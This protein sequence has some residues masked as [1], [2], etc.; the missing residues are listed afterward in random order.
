MK[1]IVLAAL[2]FSFPQAG[3]VE[4]GKAKIEPDGKVI[5]TFKHKFSSDQPIPTC[6]ITKGKAQIRATGRDGLHIIGRAGDK[7]EWRCQ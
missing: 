2:L 3:H 5:V 4:T 1:T 7:I 6:S